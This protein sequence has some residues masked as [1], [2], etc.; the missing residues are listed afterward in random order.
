MRKVRSM[1]MPVDEIFTGITRGD[2]LKKY[3]AIHS[4]LHDIKEYI[5][6]KYSFK[7]FISDEIHSS[8]LFYPR[9]F[10]LTV[11]IS[12]P[13]KSDLD[14]DGPKILRSAR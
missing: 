2:T 13:Q 6:E 1:S 4:V 3:N 5:P 8:K 9:S 7:N 10:L 12:I 11:E 14:R